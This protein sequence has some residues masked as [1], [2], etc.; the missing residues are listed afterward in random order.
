[1]S[2]AYYTV[3][4]EPEIFPKAYIVR[5]FRES[6]NDCVCLQTVNFPI[7]N[8]DLPNKTLS[9][10]DTFGRMTVKKLIDCHVM[11]KAGS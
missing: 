10:A 11:A 4:P 3:T 6:N 1:M 5:V 9:E 8:P 7:R 2:L